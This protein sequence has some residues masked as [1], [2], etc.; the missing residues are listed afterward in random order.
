MKGALLISGCD[1]R[2]KLDGLRNTGTHGHSGPA[3]YPSS[4]V[5]AGV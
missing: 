1:N 4:K 5:E 3:S 2:I